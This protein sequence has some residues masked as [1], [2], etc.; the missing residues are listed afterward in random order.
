MLIDLD[1]FRAY[2]ERHGQP[3]GDSALREIGARWR[4]QIRE[5]DLLARIG[6][7]E[8]GLLLPGCDAEAALAIVNR[9]RADIPQGLT[10]SAGVVAWRS[11]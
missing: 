2:N 10:A 8:F 4:G 1:R 11:R 3:T 6:G 5:L 7:E 9:L